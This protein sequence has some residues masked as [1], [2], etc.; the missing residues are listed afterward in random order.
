MPEL[1]WCWGRIQILMDDHPVRAVETVRSIER[2]RVLYSYGRDSASPIGVDEHHPLGRIVTNALPGSSL[3][4]PNV[5][6]LSNAMDFMFEGPE[7]WSLDHPWERVGII[8]EA[9]GLVWG[10]RWTSPRDL[11]HIQTKEG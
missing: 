7:P 5:L 6:G 1:A 9:L 8:A 4:S 2:Q 3:H 10:G 11:G